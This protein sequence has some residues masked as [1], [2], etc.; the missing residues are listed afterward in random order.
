MR[1]CL[2]GWIRGTYNY[3]TKFTASDIDKIS[4]FLLECNDTKPME[5][6][7]SIRGLDYIK[8]WKGSEFRTFLLYLG[9]VILQN[10]L[11]TEVY[12]YFLTLF[13]AVTIC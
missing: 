12:I 6:H 1:K 4:K 7:R 10:L 5:I 2:H 11:R 13:C 8:F 3:K 9:P